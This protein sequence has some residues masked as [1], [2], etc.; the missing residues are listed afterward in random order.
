MS[1]QC[2]LSGVK[3]TSRRKA[4]TSAKA[5]PVELF[6]FFPIEVR[7]GMRRGRWLDGCGLRTT[8]PN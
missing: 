8:T 5:A 3:Q 1:V 2:P 4:A 6:L 7:A